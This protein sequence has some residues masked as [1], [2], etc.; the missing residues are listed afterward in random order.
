MA[1]FTPSQKFYLKSVNHNNIAL[2]AIQIQIQTL[3]PHII[4]HSRIFLPHITRTPA[5]Y[6][7]I[8]R[9]CI[10]HVFSPALPH[11][12]ILSRYQDFSLLG[13]FAPRSES[14]T[15]N[16]RSSE[17]KFPGT[18]APGSESS[19]EL[20]FLGTKVLG[21]FRSRERKCPGTFVPE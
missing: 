19:R 11:S 8:F 21:N 14:Y 18:F 1:E 17:R 16:F 10:L 5:M 9:S 7:C 12:R 15:E 13:I 20:S 4:S 6:S 2:L 3:T